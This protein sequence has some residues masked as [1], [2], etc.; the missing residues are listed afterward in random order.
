M[1]KFWETVKDRL[2]EGERVF[3]CLVVN[4]SVHSPGTTGA[5]LALFEDG[6]TIGT[7][8]G[9]VMELNV[10][11]RG[12]A[13]LKDRPQPPSIQ[14]LVHR[15]DGDGEKSGLIC[16]GFQ[17]NLY[18]V[19][20]PEADLAPLRDIV[21]AVEDDRPLEIILDPNGLRLGSSDS[22]LQ[23]YSLQTN[24]ATWR[25][26]ENAMNL[27]RV[28][29]LGG[30][31]C[32]LSLSNM[33]RTLGYYVSIFDTRLRVNTMLV[34]DSCDEKHFIDDFSKAGSMIRAKNHTDVVVMTT[35]MVSDVEALR[36]LIG[37]AFPFVGVMGSRAKI[38]A[39]RKLLGAHEGSGALLDKLV[40][41]VGLPIGSNTPD[42]IAVSVAAQILQRRADAANEQ[43]RP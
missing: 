17:T 35:E 39:I 27:R 13:G 14:K 15:K 32:G 5:R 7:I 31:H 40:A 2:D 30:G 26:T 33:M 6:S 29:I 22:T 36:G 23:Q 42:E 1:H 4:H 38:A 34:N 3:V 18:Y 25:Y 21:A 8:G 28:A 43:V 11:A 9:G 19:L 16:A 20:R 10:L 12:K 24:D 37:Y 41:P